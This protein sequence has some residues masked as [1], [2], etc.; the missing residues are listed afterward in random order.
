MKPFIF[1]LLAAL[2]F[3]SSPVLAE[4]HEHSN[5]DGHAHEEH[6]PGETHEDH[7][8]KYHSHEH[9]HHGGDHKHEGHTHDDHHEK[10]GDED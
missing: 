9:D 5:D 4:S 3:A 10:D 7:D 2:A 8:K 6:H 1:P